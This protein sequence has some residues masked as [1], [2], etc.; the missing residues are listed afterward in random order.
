MINCIFRK[1]FLDTGVEHIV[2]QVVNPKLNS[3]FVPKIEEIAYKYLGIEKPV[4]RTFELEIKTENHQQFLPN[5]DLEQVSPDSEKCPSIEEQSPNA[6]TEDNT[7]DDRVDDMEEKIDDFESPAFEPI[8]CKI[9]KDEIVDEDDDKMDICLDDSD[10]D[11]HKSNGFNVNNCDEVKSNLSSISGLTSNESIEDSCGA[12]VNNAPITSDDVVPNVECDTIEVEETHQITDEPNLTTPPRSS[13]PEAAVQQFDAIEQ[14]E[15]KP[16]IHYTGDV[17]ENLNQDSVLSQVSSNSRLSIITNNN[18]NTRLDDAEDASNELVASVGNGDKIEKESTCPYG[19]SEEA[20]M[21]RFNESSSSNNSLV[22]DT[23]NLSNGTNQCDKRD[24]F[25]TAFD[26]KREEIKFEGTERKS[27]DIDLS[28]PKIIID[29]KQPQNGDRIESHTLV[30]EVIKTPDTVVASSTET[31]KDETFKSEDISSVSMADMN[32][33]STKIASPK[34]DG[35]SNDAKLRTED[36]KGLDESSST[37]SKHKGSKSSSSTSSSSHRNGAETDSK[38]A[39]KQR[40]SSSSSSRHR[41]HSDRSKRSHSSSHSSMS[42]EKSKSS[43]DESEGKFRSDDRS[44]KSHQKSSSSSTRTGN[45]TSRSSSSKSHKDK[46]R[47]RLD[48]SNRHS[49]SSMSGSGT[50]DKDS[51][52][53]YPSKYSDNK[54]SRSDSHRS[55]HRETDDHALHKEKP[56]PRKR[57]RSKDSNDGSAN[58]NNSL[59][60]AFA[61]TYSTSTE[62]STSTTTTVQETST[63]QQKSDEQTTTTTTT[64]TQSS[65]VSANETT[66]EPMCS[67]SALNTTKTDPPFTADDGENEFVLTTQPVV[68]DQILSGNELNLETFI[69]ENRDNPL[70][71]SIERTLQTKVKKPKMAANIHE[72]RKLMKVRKQIDREEQKKLEQARVLAKQMMRSNLTTIADDSQG[73]ELEFACMSSGTNAPGPSISSPVK[74]NSGKEMVSDEKPLKSLPTPSTSVKKVEEMS[75]SIDQAENGE[76]ET[77]NFEGFTA[78]C[79]EAACDVLQQFESMLQPA[80]TSA[81]AKGKTQSKKPVNRSTRTNDTKPIPSDQLMEMMSSNEDN[82]Q[83]FLENNKIADSDTSLTTKPLSIR[84]R[85]Y[86]ETSISPRETSAEIAADNGAGMASVVANVFITPKAESVS[87]RSGLFVFQNIPL[88][89]LNISSTFTFADTSTLDK[90]R[91]KTR[92]SNEDLFKPRP[93]L[94]GASRSRR[95]GF[96]C[97]D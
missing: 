10:D 29:E 59:R 73:V 83:L 52:S 66:M 69:D 49:S 56:V 67:P 26:I 35:T 44:S 7:I 4:N 18:T 19:I 57:S 39:S 50:R 22:I 1:G 88:T 82:R 9:I 61:S 13:P 89:V 58:P 63:D 5:L 74:F 85:K 16:S 3:N 48:K 90:Q 64:T 91:Q 84:K 77:S 93:V 95:R 78:E 97:N 75:L 62:Q 15:E 12:I 71:S 42:R 76:T 2:D 81:Q 21:Q 70:I 86:N 8:E 60:N 28:E 51:T 32:D 92:Y 20:Q 46:E 37:S 23:D 96:N 31:S 87:G 79:S 11:M 27:F 55:G 36:S 47:S 43:R 33:A 53:K 34:I 30:A 38:T 40:N 68:V 54:K 65:P 80:F 14:P 24:E 25:V 41:S 17:V 6:H 45:D 72:A 94:G